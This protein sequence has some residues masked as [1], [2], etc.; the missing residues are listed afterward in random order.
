MKKTL[1]LIAL[2]FVCSL[3][4]AQVK[5]TDVPL[6]VSRTS[7]GKISCI[8]DTNKSN[9]RI[10]ISPQDITE[11]FMTI[12]IGDDCSSAILTLQ[13]F[14]SIIE[15]GCDARAELQDVILYYSTREPSALRFSKSGYNNTQAL[16]FKSILKLHKDVKS[17]CE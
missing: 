16:S 13:D 10:I 15:K 12:S 17:F 4:F 3:S 7:G 11:T 1:F 5:M 8:C 14:I 6:I 2:S 9:F